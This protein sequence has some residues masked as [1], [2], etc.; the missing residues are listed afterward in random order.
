[1]SPAIPVRCLARPLAG[2]LV[3]PYVSLIHNGHAV[4][5]SLDADRAHRAFLQH[6]CQICAQPLQERFFVI[7][8]PADQQQGY[9]PEPALHPECQPYAAANCP[10]F[11]PRRFAISE[12][13]LWRNSRNDAPN[14][15]C[16]ALSSG[17]PP[18]TARVRSQAGSVR[19]DLSVAC[20]PTISRLLAGNRKRRLTAMR[21]TSVYPTRQPGQAALPRPNPQRRSSTVIR[22]HGSTS[23]FDEIG[24]HL[25]LYSIATNLCGIGSTDQN[26]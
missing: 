1:M 11:I 19:P 8:R 25:R 9:S 24:Y 10:M 15:G 21:P 7:V 3:V 26:R 17:T 13:M 2:G 6:L 5:G 18:R 23:E 16:R 4:F 14:G 20:D 12:A 22:T